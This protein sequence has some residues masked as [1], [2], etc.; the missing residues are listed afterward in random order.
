[1]DKAAGGKERRKFGRVQVSLSIVYRKD[2]SP[3]VRIRSGDKEAS[4]SMI[5]ISEGGIGI[6]SELQVASRTNLWIRFTL[7]KAEQKGISFFGTVEVL[8]E[9]CYCEQISEFAYRMG[10]SFVKV[11]E[12]SRKDIANFVRSLATA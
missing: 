7:S 8:G 4:A 3:E 6:I 2:E 10:I 11:D 12:R 1:M 5:D 9:V